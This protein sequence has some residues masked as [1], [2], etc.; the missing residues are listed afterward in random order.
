[1]FGNACLV[2]NAVGAERSVAFDLT[3]ACSGFVF[4]VVTA[5]Q[6]LHSGTY[7]QGPV[8]LR[9]VIF[10]SLVKVKCVHRVRSVELEHHYFTPVA[11][12]SA[13]AAFC[14]SFLVCPLENVH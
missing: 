12:A 11:N 2:A 14:P 4:A 9:R 10:T 6:F 3:V 13:C 8:T 1:M 5:S 7:K